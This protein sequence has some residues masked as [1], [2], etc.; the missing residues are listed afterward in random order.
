MNTVLPRRGLRRGFLRLVNQIKKSSFF[1]EGRYHHEEESAVFH[2]KIR[3]F[4]FTEITDIKTPTYALPYT[5]FEFFKMKTDWVFV[6]KLKLV[7][8]QIGPYLT[9]H[10]PIVA[11][12]KFL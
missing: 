3:E 7:E 11:E 4:G 5:K 1:H 10:R 2:K 9:D 8:A 6:K 12:L